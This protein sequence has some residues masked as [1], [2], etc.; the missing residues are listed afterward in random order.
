MANIIDL[1]DFMFSRVDKNNY[2]KLGKCYN[3]LKGLVVGYISKNTSKKTY[4][5]LM[6]I[7]FKD[8]N[9]SYSEGKYFKNLENSKKIYFP[10][11]RIDRVIINPAE[12]FDFLYKTYCLENINFKEN[13]TIVDCGA[14]VGEL[15]YSFEYKNLKIKYIGFEPDVYAYECLVQNL[16][17]ENAILHNIAL[18]N[19]SEESILYIDTEG[20]NS[21]MVKFNTNAKQIP[22]KSKTLDSY[23][24]KKIKLLKLEAEGSEFEVLNGSLNTLKNIDYI[25]VDYGPERGITSKLT[26]SEV[27]NFLYENNFEIINGSR[28]RYIGLFKNKN[29]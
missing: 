23:N 11:K 18:S 5:I 16:S 17:N 13:D 6:N 29:I 27:T 26:I 20:A 15:F 19:I 21:S 10:N 1:P 2:S 25:S 28:Y 14:N 22:I 3:F 8:G 24:F 12:H 7:L 9:I 4:T